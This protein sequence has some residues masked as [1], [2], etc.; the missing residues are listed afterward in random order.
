MPYDRSCA[1]RQKAH[2]IRI[3]SRM[4]INAEAQTYQTGNHPFQY[5]SRKNQRRGRFPKHP[6]RV[7]KPGTPA[8]MV[9]NVIAVY[10]SYNH[11]CIKAA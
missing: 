1:G 5:I 10:S 3:L 8:P 2:A 7:G 6:Q 11:R 9:S 4:N